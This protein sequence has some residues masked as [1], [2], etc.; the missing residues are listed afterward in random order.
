MEDNIIRRQFCD[1]IF[2]ADADCPNEEI[3]FSIVD[4]PESNL[5]LAYKEVMDYA[6]FM[7][8]VG[9]RLGLTDKKE[10]SK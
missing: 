8:A 7:Q 4:Y 3:S 9:E 10:E 6:K 1:G 5:F 2:V